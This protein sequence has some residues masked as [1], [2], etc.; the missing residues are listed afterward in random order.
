MDRELDFSSGWQS[1]WLER[2]HSGLSAYTT[3]AYNILSLIALVLGIKAII[4][5]RK[6]RVELAADPSSRAAIFSASS[7][8][9]HNLTQGQFYVAIIYLIHALAIY[10]VDTVISTTAIWNDASSNPAAYDCAMLLELAIFTTGM[11]AIFTAIFIFFPLLQMFLCLTLLAKVHRRRENPSTTLAEYIPETR[12]LTTHLGQLWSM[13]AFAMMVYWPMFDKPF[14][15]FA[16]L[17]AVLGSGI[18]WLHLSFG[19]NFRAKQFEEIV[20][21]ELVGCREA[22]TRYGMHI[23]MGRGSAVKGLPQYMPASHSELGLDEKAGV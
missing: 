14:V 21:W 2:T 18:M 9:I 3:V 4:R 12:I 10:L 11:V 15:R 13:L 8:K 22:V 6:T 20:A 16:L 1:A 19:P 5:L 23:F 17:E 7:A